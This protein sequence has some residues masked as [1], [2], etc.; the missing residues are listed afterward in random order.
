M[1]FSDHLSPD[2][3]TYIT[4]FGEKFHL[5]LIEQF[6]ICLQWLSGNKL[7]VSSVY[8]H[9]IFEFATCLCSVE[10]IGSN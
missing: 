5:V 9:K 4:P 7:S 8:A 10:I 6:I 3:Q 2:I 1:P